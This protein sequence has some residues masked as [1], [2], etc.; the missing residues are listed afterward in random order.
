MYSRSWASFSAQVVSRVM[1]SCAKPV[2]PGRT[3][4]RCQYCGIS[5]A[6]LLEEGRPDRARA[7]D[8]HVARAPRSRAGAARPDARR[9]ARGRARVTSVRGAAAS[10][11]SPRYGPSRSSASGRERAELEH[12]EDRAR[13]GPRARPRYSTGAPA[14]T[15][16]AARDQHEHRR[17]HDQRGAGD[18][19]VERA[20][21][22]CRRRGARTRAASAGS[23][24]RASPSGPI[25]RPP[26]ARAQSAW[27]ARNVRTVRRA[28]RR[29]RASCLPAARIAAVLLS[30]RARLA[31]LERAGVGQR[32]QATL[33]DQRL[34]DAA[35][36]PP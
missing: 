26:Q 9:A 27:T 8:A 35:Q 18:A 30:L 4:S 6:Q 36:P 19:D 23:A 21:R 13:R 14:V 17:E 16:I 15:R 29:R 5:L 31:Q 11:S 7:D 32:S 33:P 12:R 22:A 24:R 25:A 1:R 10:S 20:Q 28:H 2:R 34:V 3:T